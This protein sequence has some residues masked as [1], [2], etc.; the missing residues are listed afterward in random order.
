MLQTGTIHKVLIVAFKVKFH[1]QGP[2]FSHRP[3]L[4]A[5][6]EQSFLQLPIQMTLNKD[7]PTAEHKGQK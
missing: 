1:L 6:M 5:T 4:G 2:L 3:T 7:C